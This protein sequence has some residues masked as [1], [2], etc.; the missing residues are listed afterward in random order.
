MFTVHRVSHMLLKH[1]RPH[2]K[3][4]NITE[5]LYPKAVA[6]DKFDCVVTLFL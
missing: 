3:D 6:I 5:G 1:R 4:I 2:E